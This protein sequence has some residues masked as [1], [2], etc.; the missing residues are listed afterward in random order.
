MPL[1]WTR[2]GNDING[3]AVDDY[4]GNSISLCSDGS[5]LAIGAP[6]NNGNGR[7]SGHV[8][9]YGNTSGMIEN[10]IN[11]RIS[12]FPNPTTGKVRIQAEDIVGIELMDITGKTIVSL[13]GL[14][15]IDLSSGA[16]GIYFIKVTVQKGVV[17]KK[18][19]KE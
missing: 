10:T 8:R 14:K 15:E 1:D 6:C 18:I 7:D 5:I 16:K 3:E 2:I 17:V 9:V 12:V 4:S 11:S 19:V 13:T